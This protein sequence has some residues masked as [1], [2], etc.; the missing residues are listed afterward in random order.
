MD[1]AR[2]LK[3]LCLSPSS[4]TWVFGG[5]DIYEDTAYESAVNAKVLNPS[6]WSR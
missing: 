2:I 6:F 4:K 5:W 3:T 1:A